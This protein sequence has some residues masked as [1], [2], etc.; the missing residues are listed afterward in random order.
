MQSLETIK[1]DVDAKHIMLSK[2]QRQTDIINRR[3]DNTRL[4]DQIHRV[5]NS[6]NFIQQE[7]IELKAEK[8]AL[9]EQVEH[10]TAEYNYENV[11]QEVR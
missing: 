1:R 6:I 11:T 2:L 9:T 3:T 8:K 5:T 10:L 7:I 4:K